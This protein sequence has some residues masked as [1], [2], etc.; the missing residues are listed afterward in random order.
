MAAETAGTRKI[1]LDTRA[2]SPWRISTSSKVM[3]PSDSTIT[4]QASA[5]HAAPLPSKR[6]FSSRKA[7]ANPW[8]TDGLEWTHLPSPAPYH[9][10]E[11]AP[12]VK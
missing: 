1:R 5:N 11:T 12:V 9:S 2:T 3:A 10:F 8:E 7:P 6:K 4:D